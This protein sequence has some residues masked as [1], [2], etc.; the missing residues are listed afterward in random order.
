[1]RFFVALCWLHG[2]VGFHFMYISRFRCRRG[3]A[4]KCSTSSSGPSLAPI[5]HC[6]FPSIMPVKSL[7]V[8][9][10]DRRLPI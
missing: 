4:K 9:I 2:G 3:G 8:R 6:R 7:V 5:E 10:D 1:M